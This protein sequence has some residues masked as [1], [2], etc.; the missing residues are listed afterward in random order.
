MGQNQKVA[1]FT[2]LSHLVLQVVNPLLERY[3]IKKKIYIYIIMC[4]DLSPSLLLRKPKKVFV[5]ASSNMRKLG[6]TKQTLKN[7]IFSFSEQNLFLKIKKN[8]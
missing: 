4:S 3:Y 5:R 2:L 6:Y 1:I 8:K 7:S